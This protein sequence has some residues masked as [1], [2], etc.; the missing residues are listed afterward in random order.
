MAVAKY[1]E[2]GNWY[3][4]PS[5][6][7]S[8]GNGGISKETDPTVPAWA[9]QP[10]KPKYTAE[11]VGA[12]PN[13]TQIPSVPSVLPNPFALSFSGA[14]SGSYD[15]SAP[16]AIEIPQG[17]GSDKWEFIGE[18]NVG[19]EDVSEWIISEDAEGNP[20]EL[21]QMYFEIDFKAS[22]STT[23]NTKVVLGNPASAFPFRTNC[24]YTTKDWITTSGKILKTGNGVHVFCLPNG[25]EHF[26]TIAFQQ[27]AQYTSLLNVGASA[28]GGSV[29]RQC[30]G[31]IAFKSA[32]ASTGLI[33]ANSTVKIWGVRI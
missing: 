17:G 6:G 25:D 10:E 14:A 3:T 20:I 30:V 23:A 4:V 26:Y 5:V 27:I 11:E 32:D 21:K 22:P 28:N 18:F 33:G 31:G 16:L 24:A 8:G 15:G 19:D 13:T 9:K 29:L 12:L 1:K 7:T 2:N